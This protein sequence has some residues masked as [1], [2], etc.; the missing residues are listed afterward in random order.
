MVSSSWG[1]AM[2]PEKFQTL[3]INT[4]YSNEATL[5]GTFDDNMELP[6]ITWRTLLVEI[7]SENLDWLKKSEGE[8]F[9]D[10]YGI[11]EDELDNI[12]SDRESEKYYD[13][14]SFHY[15]NYIGPSAKAFNLIRN[16]SNFPTDKDGNGHYRGIELTQTY[17]NGPRKSVY[18]ENKDAEEWLKT[19]FVSECLDIK[20]KRI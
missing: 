11:S 20:I 19:Q 1:F 4:L 7:L 16:L 10:H 9:L 12:L 18:V 15:D 3:Y 2:M 13:D 8:N 6:E 17:A 5:G 14:I